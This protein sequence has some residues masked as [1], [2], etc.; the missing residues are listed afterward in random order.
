MARRST[1]GLYRRKR[2]DGAVECISTSA[3]S[4][5]GAFARALELTM[6]RKLSGT[7]RG[8]W[9]RSGKDLST[10]SGHVESGEMP[11]LDT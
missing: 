4:G 10:V 11:Q 7:S 8:G 5:S 9:R 3:S 1:P 6:K 2:A